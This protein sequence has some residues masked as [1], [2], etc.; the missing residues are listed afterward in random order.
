MFPILAH[1]FDDDGKSLSGASKEELPAVLDEAAQLIPVSVHKIFAFWQ[2]KRS[3][4]HETRLQPQ[5]LPQH[6]PRNA[7][8]MAAELTAACP[9]AVL[10]A[11]TGKQKL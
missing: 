7:G 5:T 10:V 1:L 4:E 8:L 9:A 6:H 2:S 3:T 11:A